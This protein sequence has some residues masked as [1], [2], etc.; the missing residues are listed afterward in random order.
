MLTTHLMTRVEEDFDFGSLRFWVCRTKG[1]W[2]C[3]LRVYVSGIGV[4]VSQKMPMS[5]EAGIRPTK[6]M[7]LSAGPVPRFA[8]AALS[9]LLEQEISRVYMKLLALR[10]PQCITYRDVIQRPRSVLGFR[11]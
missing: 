5:C 8:T 1:W 9:P 2:A 7:P 6:D 3:G 11:D 10:A 4:G